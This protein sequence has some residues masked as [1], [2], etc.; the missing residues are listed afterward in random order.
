MIDLRYIK[1]D[2]TSFTNEKIQEYLNSSVIRGNFKVW[3]IV[4]DEKLK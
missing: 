4:L 1:Y 2:V 3:C